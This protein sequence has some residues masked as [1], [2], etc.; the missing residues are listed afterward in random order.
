[1]SDLEDEDYEDYE[2]ESGEPRVSHVYIHVN[3]D[4]PVV[5]HH[6]MK[7]SITLEESGL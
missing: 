4:E 3:S 6:E 5:Y 1:M 2:E 7:M